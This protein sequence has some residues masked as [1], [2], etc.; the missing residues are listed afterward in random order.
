M[1]YACILNKDLSEVEHIEMNHPMYFMSSWESGGF[2]E[3]ASVF[4][5]KAFFPGSDVISGM[6]ECMSGAGHP[7]V[8]ATA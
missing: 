8:F 3:K 4:S 1:V 7:L 6:P 2:L 5:G